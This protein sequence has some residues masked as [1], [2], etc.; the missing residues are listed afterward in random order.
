M[1][2]DLVVEDQ[3]QQKSSLRVE[4]K[5]TVGAGDGYTYHIFTNPNSDNL[6]VTGSGTKPAAILLIGGGGGGVVNTLVV[7]VQAH[8]YVNPDYDLTAGTYPVTIGAGGFGTTS[9]CSWWWCRI[10]WKWYCRW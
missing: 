2:L 7:A 5:Y 1:V 10:C 8:L 4:Q 9:W 3:E 6:V